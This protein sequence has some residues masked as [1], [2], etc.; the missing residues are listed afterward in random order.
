MF[1]ELAATSM[2]I[3]QSVVIKGLRQMDS[4]IQLT[5]K[6]IRYTW[7]GVALETK[8]LVVDPTSIPILK[9]SFTQDLTIFTPVLEPKMSYKFNMILNLLSL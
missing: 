9:H 4:T 3:L 7:Y 5:P 2:N 1:L 8:R 6:V